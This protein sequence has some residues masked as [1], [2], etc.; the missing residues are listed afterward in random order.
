[1]R[2]LIIEDEAMIARRILRMTKLYFADVAFIHHCD[3]LSA[4][5]SFIEHKEIDL[6]LLDLN[7]NG[8]DGFDVLKHMVA[9]SFHTIIISAYK[10]RAITAFEFGV[11]DFVS[12]PFNENRL[13]QAFDRLKGQKV[14]TSQHLKYLTVQRLG[15]KAL[16]KIEDIIY[17][18][19]ARI[20]TEIVLKN[21]KREIHNKSLEA[22]ISILPN[23]FERIHKSYIV[24]MERALAIQVASGGKYALVLENNE[25]IPV[26]RTKYKALKD[27]WF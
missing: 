18:Q 3:S 20:Y 14:K 19:G 7:L 5:L 4:G 27:K 13:H 16:I 12:K 9:M 23:R 6:L 25:E 15:E 24:D 22:L 11:L 21:G 1:M 2:I 26:S 8:D 17:I 10:D